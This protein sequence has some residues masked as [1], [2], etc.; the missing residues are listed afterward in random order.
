MD[1][2]SA[3]LK[4]ATGAVKENV[5][6]MMGSERM[7]AEGKETRAQANIEHERAQAEG[8]TQGAGEK[9]K[10]EMK[11]TAGGA[12]G[13]RQMETEGKADHIKGDARMSANTKDAWP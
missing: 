1:K 6:E 5:G 12:M 11:D 2:A 8:Y 9:F 10:G 3:N 4:A 13:N 7:A